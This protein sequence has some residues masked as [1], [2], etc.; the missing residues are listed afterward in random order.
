MSPAHLAGF[1]LLAD[2][3]GLLVF[4]GTL[5]QVGVVGQA[6]E[7]RGHFWPSVHLLLRDGNTG[8]R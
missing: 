7:Q 1:L 5:R 2:A 8:E 4:L 3:L 6:T